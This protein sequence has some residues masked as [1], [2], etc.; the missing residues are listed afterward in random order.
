MNIHLT[1]QKKKKKR[2]QI[3]EISN[4][5]KTFFLIPAFSPMWDLIVVVCGGFLLG[6]LYVDLSC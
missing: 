3:N 2:K 1:Y 5:V 4:N 6:L